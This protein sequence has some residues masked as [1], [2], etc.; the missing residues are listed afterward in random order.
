MEKMELSREGP[1]YQKI[2]DRLVERENQLSKL[3]SEI[4]KKKLDQ[5]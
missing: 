5:S 4:K 2:M 1:S 3:L